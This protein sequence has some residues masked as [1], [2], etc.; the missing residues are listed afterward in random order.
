M[1]KNLENMAAYQTMDASVALI[2]NLTAPGVVLMRNYK[3]HPIEAV[4]F[5]EEVC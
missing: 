5:T 4:P 2:F 1:A 3:G